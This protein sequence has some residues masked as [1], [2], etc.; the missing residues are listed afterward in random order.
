MQLK[1]DMWQISITADVLINSFVRNC[2]YKRV[3]KYVLERLLGKIQ[4]EKI[5]KLIILA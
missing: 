5:L 4:F 3:Y 2:N 1:T